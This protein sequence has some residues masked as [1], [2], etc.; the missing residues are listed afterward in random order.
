MKSKMP[1]NEQIHSHWLKETYL[2]RCS[3]LVFGDDVPDSEGL[4]VY[5][6]KGLVYICKK[7]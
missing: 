6:W 5:V 3:W 7:V 1:S 2:V 4:W